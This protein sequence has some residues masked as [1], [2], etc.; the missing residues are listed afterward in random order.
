MPDFM[1]PPQQGLR[2]LWLTRMDPDPPDAGDLTYSFHLLSSLSQAGVQLTVL[3][4]RRA[5]DRARAASDGGIE[6]VA[7]PSESDREIGGR[8][9]VRSLFSHLPNVAAQYYTAS[10]RRALRAQMTRDWDAIVVDNVG[11]GWVWPE[12]QVYRRRKPGLVSVFIA[13]QCEGEV[14]RGMARNF[15]G[16]LVRKIGLSLDAAKVDR[17][18]KKLVRQSDLVSAI[19]AEDLRCFGGLDKTVLLTPGYAGRHVAS[20]AINDATPRRALI[21]GSAIWLAKQMNLSEFMAA[22]DELFYQRQIELWVVGKVA[23]HLATHHFRATRFLGFVEDLEPIFR[24]VRIGIVAERTGGGFKLKTLDYIFNRVPI[25]TIRGGIA[26]LPLTPGVHYLCFE[27]MREL[28]H[29][30]AAVIDDI[31]RL[32][33]VQQGAYERCATGFD[34]SERGRTLCDAIQQ[35]VNRQCAAHAR[36][37]AL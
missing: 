20:R 11:M 5:G 1:Q 3:A 32:N 15:R 24:S 13:H 23:E 4:M 7:V 9:A 30:V 19:T 35:A 8:L 2:C 29:G 26:G 6:W 21:L 28:A 12:V 16:N 25:A 33:S 36:R 17:L 18:E 22:A 34:W 10:F 31:E 37:S 27:S 14:R